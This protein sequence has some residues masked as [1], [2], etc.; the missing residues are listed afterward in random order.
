[1][2]YPRYDS[3][4]LKAGN[5]LVGMHEPETLDPAQQRAS[6]RL[7]CLIQWDTNPGP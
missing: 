5:L 6:L 4:L 7:D 1:M 3:D 2:K